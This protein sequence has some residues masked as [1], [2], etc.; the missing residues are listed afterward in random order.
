MTQ[1]NMGGNTVYTNT[2]GIKF[3]DGTEQITAFIEPAGS[4]TLFVDNDRTNVF[5]PDGTYL[6]PYPTIMGAINRIVAN[7]DNTATKAYTVNISGGNYIETIDL[8]NPALVNLVFIGNDSVL[9]GDNAMTQPVL[10]A[11]NNDNLVRVL[12]YGIEFALNG[13]STHGINFS[14]TT[15]NTNLGEHG[16]VFTQ[17]G[18]Q[19][20]TED[21]YFNNVSFVLFDNTGVTANIN[22]TNVNSLQFVNGN[23]PNPQTPFVIVTNTSAPTPT[24]WG[25]YSNASFMGVGI[26][27]ITT[28][29]LSKVTVQ[30]CI[31]SGVIT[32]A[33]AVNTFVIINS[34][35]IGNITVNAGGILGIINSLVSQP[36]A[37]ATATVTVNGILL[38]A[39]SFITGTPIIVNSGG[40]FVEEGGMHDDGQLTVN[41]GG[42]YS[43]QGDMAVGTLALSEHLNN[44]AGNPDIAGQ[45][46]INNGTA[47][48]FTFENPFN[49]APS[50]VVTPTSDPTATGTYWVTTTS[51]GFTINVKISGTITFQ[52]HCIGNPN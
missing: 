49:F 12:F 21:V 14:S 36:T 50:V 40:Y 38:S 29:A 13:T 5:V 35:V 46:T 8:S 24:G 37:P 48:S 27:S 15:Q 7:G 26:G 10:Q 17:C 28:D 6:R 22:A 18:M 9:V 41:S 32:D 42:V 3:A 19:D 52:Y 45:L 11:I 51:T 47:T 30:S 31:V 4:T 34:A 44:V 1:T 43:A 20:N 16:I 25:G 2:L 23:G 39:L 33:S